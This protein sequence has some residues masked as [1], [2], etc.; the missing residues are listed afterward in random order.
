MSEVRSISYS[1][2]SRPKRTVPS[3]SPPSRSSIDGDG[4]PEGMEPGG[5]PAVF[6]FGVLEAGEVIGAQFAV[7]LPGDHDVPVR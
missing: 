1:A 2:P 4:A 3:A 6:A 7:R 5:E